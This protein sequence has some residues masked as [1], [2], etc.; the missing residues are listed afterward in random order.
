[1]GAPLRSEPAFPELPPLVMDAGLARVAG[2][3]E[4]LVLDAGRL[5]G[6]ADALDAQVAVDV[7]R[8]EADE[9]SGGDELLVFGSFLLDRLLH[10]KDGNVGL[11]EGASLDEDA[12]E[13]DEA[14]VCVL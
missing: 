14:Q 6:E 9:S 7:R 3:A 5:A 12:Q 13:R 8:A 1:M 10:D 2:A 11:V 4:D